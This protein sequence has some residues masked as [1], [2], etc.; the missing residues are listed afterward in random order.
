MS[1]FLGFFR[2]EKTILAV[3]L[4]IALITYIQCLVLGKSSYN[5]F[6]IFREAFFHLVNHQNLHLEYPAQYYDLFLYTPAFTV[7]F[8]PFSLP[9][10]AVGLFLWLIFST[11]FSFWAIKK[12]PVS[13]D[14]KV[15]I[16]WFCLL[17]LNTSLHNVQTNSSI[18]ALCLL[19]FACLE[20]RLLFWAALCPAIA[21]C[22]KGYGVIVVVLYLF[23]PEKIKTGGYFILCLAALMLL[24]LPF[25]G[26]QRWVE[27]YQEWYECLQSDRKVNIGLGV[28]GVLNVFFPGKI[29]I[30]LVQIAGILGLLLTTGILY[31]FSAASRQIRLRWQFLAY[32][33]IWVIIF[34]HAA[35]SASYITAISGVAVWYVFSDRTG[36]DKFWLAFVFFFS[37][38]APF[39]VYPSFIRSHFF[40]PYCIKAIGCIG[41]WCSLQLSLLKQTNLWYPK[42]I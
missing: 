14:S 30:L 4:L 18:A 2:S 34:N 25:T 36:I 27:I 21:F 6:T 11:L 16:W 26:A 23:Y 42:S 12:L 31:W 40:G 24:P 41:V 38:L 13:Q 22:I 1:K 35:E 20:R 8:L 3:Y 5:N 33:L 9:P 7:F 17:E 10:V 39:D 19:T 32:L 15:F 28:M 29:N 37:I